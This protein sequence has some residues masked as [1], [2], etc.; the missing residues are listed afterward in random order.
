MSDTTNKELTITWCVE[1]IQELEPSWSLAQCEQFLQEQGRLIKQLM[2]AEGWVVLQVLVG[3]Y[4]L[5]EDKFLLKHSNA[6][7][8]GL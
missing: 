8:E 3:E 7:K 5:S 1:D 2:V 6:Q 4:K